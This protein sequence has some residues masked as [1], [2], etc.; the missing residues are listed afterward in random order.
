MATII[1][2]TT[3]PPTPTVDPAKLSVSAQNQNAKYTSLPAGAT[4][5]VYSNA[6]NDAA[7]A[8]AAGIKVNITSSTWTGASIAIGATDYIFFTMTDSGGWT[9]PMT[10]DG[11]IPTNPDG[12]GA[13]T[14]LDSIQATSKNTVTSSA[15]GNVAGND[16]ITLYVGGTAYSTAT[17]VGSTMTVAPDLVAGNAPTYTRTNP[18]GHESV[19]SA[20]DGEILILTMAAD[21]NGG[22]TAGTL[23]TGD[24]LILS[25]GG[26][27]KPFNVNVPI[28]VSNIS[29]VATGTA[30]L[31]TGVL[32][33]PGTAFV[34][35]P[36]T[37][38][39]TCTDFATGET[40]TFNILPTTP[41]V[42]M[43]GGNQV[44][45]AATPTPFTF[46]DTDF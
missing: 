1:V 17:P 20:A 16:K 6:A 11:Q 36:L 28:T 4:V 43:V 7:L 12:P 37:A 40:V 30:T 21:D 38:T 23:E 15:A 42:D 3:T 45:P 5:K 41:I 9:S 24:R 18:D 27:T 2:G 25:F 8:Q 10:A 22:G 33:N 31:G 39:A 34:S 35:V 26:P 32:K 19:I 13:G 14:A 29:W 44:L 46:D